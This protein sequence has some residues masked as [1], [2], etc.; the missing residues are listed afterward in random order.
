MK[1]LKKLFEIL[2]DKR[3]EKE[4]SFRP[5]FIFKSFFIFSV[6]NYKQIVYIIINTMNIFLNRRMI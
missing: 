2:K 4:Y 1:D 3:I 6:D 5:F